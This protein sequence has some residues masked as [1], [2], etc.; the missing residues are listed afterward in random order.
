MQQEA[1]AKIPKLLSTTQGR[2]RGLIGSLLENLKTGRV[3]K[4]LELEICEE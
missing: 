1:R 2:A 3:T 4:T